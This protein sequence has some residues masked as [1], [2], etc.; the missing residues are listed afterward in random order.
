MELSKA[1]KALLAIPSKWPPI[2]LG[3]IL[4]LFI[5]A[6]FTSN[7]AMRVIPM[8]ESTSPSSASSSTITSISSRLFFFLFR[9]SYSKA[10][11]THEDHVSSDVPGSS[12]SSSVLVPPP[13]SPSTEITGG[14]NGINNVQYNDTLTG[15]QLNNSSRASKASSLDK[16]EDD[17]NSRGSSIGAKVAPATDSTQLTDTPDK[18]GS[19]GSNSIDKG[20]SVE[21]DGE[22][23]TTQSPDQDGPSSS[24]FPINDSPPLVA[25]ETDAAALMDDKSSPAGQQPP[26]VNAKLCDLSVGTWVEDDSY[27][28]YHPGS[29]PFVD[30][31]FNCQQNGRP[32]SKYN[33]WRWAPRDCNVPRFNGTHLLEMLRGKRLVFVGD[34]LNRNQWE[35]MLCMLRESLP[36]KRQIVQVHGGRITKLPGAYVF[37][38]VDYDCKVEFYA[39]PYL[40]DK[41]DGL[42]HT[43][44]RVKLDRMDISERRWRK[45][46]VLVFNTGHWW[47]PDKIGQGDNRF[48]EGLTLHQK[49]NVSVAYT[50]ALTTWAKWVDTFVNPLNTTVFFRG[51]SPVHYVGG[52]WNS[53][54]QCHEET[55]PIYNESFIAPYPAKMEAVEEVLQGM[56]LSVQMLN[57]TRLSDFRKDA[58][59]AIYGHPIH[60]VGQYQDCSHWCLPGLPD[61]WNE[62]LYY[63]LVN[64]SVLA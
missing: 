18:N 57:I 52:Q 12:S 19:V 48:Q 1:Q 14:D 25:K 37:K 3:V 10:A 46:N 30:E 29:C 63:A 54:G 13:S 5:S 22:A 44:F 39:S 35:S 2:L 36:D 47:T 32:D 41:E 26:I 33:R 56:K 6:I 20:P 34:S 15:E 51:Y 55:E 8:S 16:S 31:S 42:N 49:M 60:H 62:L 38:F 11:G 28:F 64:Q 27:P 50:K 58:H 9:R 45:A 59:P 61:T 40:V 53:G 17:G 43:D 23:I 21:K 7:F 24:L 4:S